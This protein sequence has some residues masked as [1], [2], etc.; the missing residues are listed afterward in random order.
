MRYRLSEIAAVCGGVFTGRDREVGRVI[1][2]SRSER[3]QRNVDAT[4]VEKAAEAIADVLGL[5]VP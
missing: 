3:R 5:K 1:V 2:D 4:T